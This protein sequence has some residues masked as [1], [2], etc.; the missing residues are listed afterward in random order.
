MWRQAW[1][2][3][4]GADWH[5]LAPTA[6]TTTAV[7]VR[8]MGSAIGSPSPKP[9]MTTLA[10]T[11]HRGMGPAIPKVVGLPFSTLF[12][13]SHFSTCERNILMIDNNDKN[14]RIAAWRSP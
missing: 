5:P 2:A 4:G 8:P 10:A 9:V 13:T 7:N 14:K 11:P 3:N 1:G 12:L 6:G